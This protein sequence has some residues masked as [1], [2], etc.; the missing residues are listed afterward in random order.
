MQRLMILKPFYPLYS[1]Q[2]NHHPQRNSVWRLLL[3][4][5]R[6][7]LVIVTSVSSVLASARLACELSIQVRGNT[8]ADVGVVMYEHPERGPWLWVV[9]FPALSFLCLFI[10]KKTLCK[11]SNWLYWIGILVGIPCSFICFIILWW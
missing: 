9:A 4:V 3:F 7:A 5:I 2:I 1:M 6:S 10:I 11:H 8:S